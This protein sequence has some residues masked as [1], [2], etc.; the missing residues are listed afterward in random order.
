MDLF[1]SPETIRNGGHAPPS[2]EAAR[3]H[4]TASATSGGLSRCSAFPPGDERAAQEVRSRPA[5]ADRDD[6]FGVQSNAWPRS[7]R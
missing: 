1:Q 2:P 4:L 5:A 3:L 7:A 6:L